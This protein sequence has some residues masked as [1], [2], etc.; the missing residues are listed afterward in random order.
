MLTL[1]LPESAIDARRNAMWRKINKNTAAAK[2][3]R[4]GP[5]RVRGFRRGR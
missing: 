5:I 2:L 3:R 4:K 1:G